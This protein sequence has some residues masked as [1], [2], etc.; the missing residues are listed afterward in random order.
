MI[1]NF[2]INNLSIGLNIENLLDFKIQVNKRTGEE[3]TEEKIRQEQEQSGGL[4][5]TAHDF[6]EF[7]EWIDSI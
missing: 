1:D 4:W 7:K 3:L 5:F 6:T 2:K